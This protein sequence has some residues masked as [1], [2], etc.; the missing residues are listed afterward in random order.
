MGTKMGQLC[1]MQAKTQLHQKYPE[2]QDLSRYFYNTWFVTHPP[3]EIWNVFDLPQSLR[4]NNSIESWNAS[5][6]KEIC[7][8]K[9]N[10]WLAIRFLKGEEVLINALLGQN[11]TAERRPAQRRKWRELNENIAVLKQ[12]IT[13]RE[14]NLDEYWISIGSL[15]ANDNWINKEYTVVSHIT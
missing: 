3:P 7:R 4:T 5:W 2:L 9:P 13:S 6:N 14:R 11:E 8:T 1:G 10:I 15:C 12:Q